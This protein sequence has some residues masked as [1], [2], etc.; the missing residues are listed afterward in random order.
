MAAVQ[1]HSPTR[2]LSAAAVKL[3]P[4]A[5]AGLSALHQTHQSRSRKGLV[6]GFVTGDL[7]QP[8]SHQ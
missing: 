8:H 4:T 6:A 2:W 3:T 7:V 5:R 1:N